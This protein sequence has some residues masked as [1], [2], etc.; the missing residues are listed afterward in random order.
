MYKD[1]VAVQRSAATK[2]IQVMS[3]A[4]EI[5]QVEGFSLFPRRAVPSYRC[6]SV[7]LALHTRDVCSRLVLLTRILS[8]FYAIVDPLKRQ[9]TLWHHP[10]L[11]IL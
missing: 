6:G 11:P 8:A 3:S 7:A 9:V 1:L 4:Y 2:Q 10:W 5:T